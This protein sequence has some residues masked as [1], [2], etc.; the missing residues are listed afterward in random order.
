MNTLTF[1]QDLTACGIHLWAEG[2]SLKLDAPSGTVTPELKA[3]L[4][5]HKAE[6]LAL[7]RAQPIGFYGPQPSLTEKPVPYEFIT[8]WNSVQRT[9]CPTCDG[10]LD[11]SARGRNGAPNV[12][13]C[14][15]CRQF[16]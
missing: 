12:W 8:A 11:L 16:A 15:G 13:W 7:L 14:A 9:G 2:D 10:S 1:L 4:K 6:I 5:V 3:A